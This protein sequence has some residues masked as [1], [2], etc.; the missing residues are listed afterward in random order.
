MAANPLDYFHPASSVAFPRICASGW[1]EPG[2]GKTYFVC[3]APDPIIFFSFDDGTEGVVEEFVERGKDIRVMKY[4]WLPVDGESDSDSL[5]NEAIAVRDQFVKDYT[6][7]VQVLSKL[8]RGTIAIDK[9]SD[10][11]NCVRYSFLGS[12][13]ADAPRDYD[14]PNQFMRKYLQLPKKTTLN[15]FAMQGHKDE[16]KSMSQKSGAI[17]R[18]GFGETPGLLNLDL[19][20][21]REAGQFF[22]TP[23]KVRGQHARGLTDIRI[24]GLDYKTLGMM[25]FPDADESAFE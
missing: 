9:E 17:K 12:P 23:G 13:K 1:G 5:Q 20:F 6:R 25:M 4:D 14:K 19:F 18:T 24:Q 11:W 22:V 15:F 16:W 7:A 2:T 8:G 10:L 21:E 3:G